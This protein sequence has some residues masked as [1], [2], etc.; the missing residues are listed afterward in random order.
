MFGGLGAAKQ[1]PGIGP[2]FSIISGNEQK[3]AYDQEAWAIGRQAD[4]I[5]EEGMREAARTAYNVKKFKEQQ[6]LD[7]ASSGGTLQGSP[8]AV[9]TETA[10]LGAQE[11]AAIRRRAEAQNE[12]LTASGL[13]MLRRGNFASFSGQANALQQE[14]N[15]QSRAADLKQQAFSTGL[16]G[17][18]AG[19]GAVGSLFGGGGGGGSAF[20]ASG[21]GSVQH[22]WLGGSAL[23]GL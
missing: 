9:L 5:Y 14:F 8:M 1:G 21:F 11:V 4:I 6:A 10:I 16:Q 15:A 23:G 2:L 3:A 18:G 7:F 12:L 20:G 13:Q 19:I 22:S 17:L